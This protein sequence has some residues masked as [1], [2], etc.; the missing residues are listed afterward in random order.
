GHD[1]RLPREEPA[2]LRRHAIAPGRA[3]PGPRRCRRRQSG[4]VDA[5]PERPGAG[6]ARADGQLSRAVEKP[7]RAD[8]GADGPAVA[9][10]VSGDAW[11][12][13]AAQAL[14][15]VTR[16]LAPEERGLLR[17]AGPSSAKIG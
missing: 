9:G 10:A 14:N 15:E 11:V 13:T 2:D 8:A 17:G 3:D 4:T 6:A 7:V 5:V 16:A 12:H 1:G